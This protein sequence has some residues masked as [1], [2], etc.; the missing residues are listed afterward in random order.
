[1]GGRE[2][3][4]RGGRMLLQVIARLCNR[5]RYWVIAVVADGMGSMRW[6]EGLRK[7]VQPRIVQVLV[8]LLRVLLL[9]LVVVVVAV[10]A[11]V[12]L[13]L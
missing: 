8:L 12:K 10:G 2:G 9:L 7:A 11:V 13:I 5:I 1:M 6:W 4:E 3:Y